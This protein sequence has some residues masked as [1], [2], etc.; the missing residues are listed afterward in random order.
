[1]RLE[2]NVKAK[3]RRAVVRHIQRRANVA[4]KRSSLIRVRGHKVNQSK[5]S[6][7]M[8]ESLIDGVSESSAST[9]RLSHNCVVMTGLIA[10]ALPSCISIYTNSVYERIEQTSSDGNGSMTTIDTKSTLLQ[11]ILQYASQDANYIIA[12]QDARLLFND[13]QV[14]LGSDFT[15]GT[16][17]NEESMSSRMKEDII[18]IRNVMN[19]TEYILVSRSLRGT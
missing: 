1:M 6:R 8:K 15:E 2:R 14:I 16:R 10:I 5:L 19:V 18:T 4:G 11:R 9:S 17:D 13:L 7:W 3:E 12:S